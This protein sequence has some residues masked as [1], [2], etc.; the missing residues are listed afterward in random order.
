MKT[1]FTFLLGSLVAFS[2]F[3][4]DQYGRLTVT[5]NG[6]RDYRV[7]VDGRN[8]GGTNRIYL[9]DIGP[10][11]HTIQVFPAQSNRGRK[12]QPIHSVNFTMRP[13]YDMNIRVLPNGRLQ[14]DE[15]RINNRNSRDSRDRDDRE[16]R[17]R[18]DRDDRDDRYDRQRGDRDWRDRD[19]RDR[20]NDDRS[21]G[22]YNDYNRAMSDAD[23][24]N[25]V[26]RVRSQ[27]FGKM[28]TA[29]EGISTHYFT[30]AQVRQVLQ[31]FNSENDRL[32]L[33]RLSYRRVV[34]PRSFTQ[35]YD[36]FSTTG[37]ADLD[38]YTRE[39]RY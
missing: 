2:A 8:Y 1:L 5:L 9:N 18:R 35:L 7:V 16:E 23:F 11:R 39:N 38:R 28:N 4:A 20:G 14:F 12:I 33:A 6:N 19:E 36:L 31:L 21:R 32:E 34:D 29:R 17:Y 25:F 37:Q 10:G 22:G 26:Q 3:A 15:K 24:N 27:W 30:T 13:D